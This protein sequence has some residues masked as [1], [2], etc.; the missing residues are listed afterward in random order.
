M[1]TWTHFEDCD[2]P[3]GE[4]NESDAPS[5][6]PPRDFRELFR[7]V[8][9]VTFAGFVYFGVR[10]L[11]QGSPSEAIERGLGILEWEESLGIAIERE[12]QQLIVG[13]EMLV[14]LANWVYI[15]FHWPVIIATLVWLHRNHRLE[16][17]LLRNAMF[18]SGAIGMVIFAIYPV[19]P[20]RLTEAGFIDTVTDLST[21]YRVLQ[22]PALVNKYAAVP[23]LHVGWNLL[24]GIIVLTV[25][26]HT[27]PRIFAALSPLAMILAVVLTANHY[28]ID[29]VAGI[30]VAMIGLAVAQR[31][32]AS[33]RSL[34]RQKDGS[35]KPEKKNDEP[36]LSP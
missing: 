4:C 29:A 17:L 7:Q 14:T 26:T 30:I 35:P 19:A 36:K 3:G 28:V 22:P 6:A 32:P 31:I 8:L 10:G 9:L 13:S 20:P 15:W 2:S 23:S 16:Y 34:G 21:S 27:I 24:V 11:T 18:V 5:G 33:M 25:A 12:A 1:T